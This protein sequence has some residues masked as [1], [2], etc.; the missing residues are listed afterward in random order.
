M[1]HYFNPELDAEDFWVN[2]EHKIVE[3]SFGAIEL[4]NDVIH[5]TVPI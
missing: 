1:V 3:L 5:K 4:A 2:K